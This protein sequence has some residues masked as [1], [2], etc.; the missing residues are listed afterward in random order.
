MT[1][2]TRRCALR[3]ACCAAAAVLCLAAHAQGLGPNMFGIP[4]NFGMSA[5]VT[6]RGFAMG[7]PISCVDDAQFGNPAFA[8]F[9]TVPDAGLRLITT[10]F[11]HGPRLTSVQANYVHPLPESQAGLQVTALSLSSS[12]ENVT[13]PGLGPVTARLSERAFLVD[14]GRRV[15]DGLTAGLAVLGA[16]SVGLRFTSAAGPNLIDLSAH[17]DYGFRGGVAYEWAPGSFLGFIYD[18]SQETVFTSGMAATVQGRTVF[19]STQMALGVSHHFS[20]NLLA[21]CEFEHGRTKTGDT[22]SSRDVWHLGAEYLPA[23]GWAVRAGLSDTAPCFGAGYDAGA[24]RVDY[25]F[26]RNWNHDAAGQ[27]FGGSDSHAL[28]GVYRW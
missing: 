26:A 23:P 3:A 2:T 25:A 28:Q 14:Y 10:G 24:W 12:S 4:P 17:A 27:L 6:A 5:P 18:F 7:G 21:A 15:A 20:D 13:L 11:E 22:G 8:P 1:G 16:E 19:R 9:H